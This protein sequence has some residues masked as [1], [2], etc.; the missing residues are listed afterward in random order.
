MTRV[1]SPRREVTNGN[2]TDGDADYSRAESPHVIGGVLKLFLRQLPD[3][4]LTTAKYNAFIK[5]GST[6]PDM[7]REFGT[8]NRACHRTARQ[9]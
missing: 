1:N 8:S 9:R 7:P 6:Y 3:P 5:A 2:V 4:L